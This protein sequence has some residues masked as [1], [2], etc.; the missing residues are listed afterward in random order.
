MGIRSK[1]IWSSLQVAR[2][3]C[4][5]AVVASVGRAAPFQ[6]QTQSVPD[7]QL[8]VFRAERNEVE[9]VVMV[10]DA[11]GQPVSGL[12][13]SDFQ[14]RDNGEL[15]TISSFAVQ[16]TIRQAV[17]TQP[18]GGSP[19]AISSETVQRRF[20]A[21]FFDDLHTEPG[22][23]ARVQKAAERF[24]A[25]SLQPDDRAA[26]FKTS[27]N[28][29]VSFT[30]DRPKWLAAIDALRV[31]P[32]ENSSK[33]TQ[34]PRITDYEA[35]LIANRLDREA[36]STVADRLLDCMCPPPHDP[37][38]CPKVEDLKGM[39]EGDAKSMWQVQRNTSQH[40]LAA[41]DLAVHALETVPR[42]RVLVLSSSG[43]LSGD[44]EQGMDRVID[45]ALHGGVVIN[46]LSA[47]GVSADSPDGNLSE[48]RLDGT[49]SVSAA[50]SRYETQ[51][52][53]ARMQAEN[54][55]MTTLAHSTGGKLFKNNNDFASG[56][57]ELAEP[58]VSYVLA[59]SPDPLKHDGKFHKLKVELKGH[60]Q[61]TVY[62]RKGYF[63]ATLKQVGSGRA[64]S[65]P[66]PPLTPERNA[67]P[68]A[69]TKAAPS[70]VGDIQDAV[71]SQA[72]P[73]D[74]PAQPLNET[75]V[76][77]GA[78]SERDASTP[79]VATVPDSVAAK[80]TPSEGGAEVASEQAFLHLASREVEHYIQAFA[81]LTADEVRVMRSFDEH[82][83]AAKERIIQSVLVIYR[84]RNDKK[85]VAEF[86]E[87][88]SVDGHEVKEHGTRAAKLWRELA[89]A[90]SPEEEVKRI[91]S[92]SERYDIGINETGFTLY[93]GLP[94]RSQ[95]EGDFGF[96]EVR[97]EMAN[98]HPV[99]VFAYRQIHPCSIV[100][101]HFLLPD[102]FADA[103]LLD[104]GEMALD[105]ETGQ[106]VREERNVYVGNSG[107]HLPRVAH[108]AMDYAESR[109]GIRVPKKIV[110]E[111]FLPGNAI[112]RT[113]FDFR[114]H[115]RMVQTYGPFS[116][117]E[118]STGEKASLPPR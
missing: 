71:P 9:V 27:D 41:L 8:P 83:F 103:P 102:Q 89:E 94:L 10:S 33:A 107:K 60:A 58:Q 91:R 54:E 37:E 4:Y 52:L 79:A 65:G 80:P 57:T 82:G 92:D 90:H 66:V 5:T 64:E 31:H 106:V 78:G 19:M 20:I 111:T 76:A 36:L 118:V 97:R 110:I 28:A 55:G 17:T 42:R 23:F 29:E 24:V 2:W 12:T 34:C 56:L 93:E 53:S 51:E 48:Q 35:Y 100:A 16:G 87:V 104:T 115:A 18:T 101:Y 96:H 75:E 68:P 21:L 63:T 44:P 69:D 11:K 112:D 49:T 26:I 45:T 14:I 74:A 6:Q 98:G 59:F 61:V 7:A 15:Q 114:L 108:L 85:S 50:R 81:D 39:V 99:R 116:R 105:A 40:V 72:K 70:V 77:K 25:D 47:K 109:F 13:Q 88:I 67:S 32:A 46:A 38:I 30:N 113:S 43:F 3:V 86:R 95:C 1:W 84:L 117:F 22:D 62:A 73:G